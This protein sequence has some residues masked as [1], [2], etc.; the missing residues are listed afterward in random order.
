MAIVPNIGNPT[1]VDFPLCTPNRIIAV[2]PV[3]VVTPLYSGEIV[4]DNTT[5]KLAYY[6]TSLSSSSWVQF[7]YDGD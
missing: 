2:N 1:P 4:L 6:A 7:V 5:T 3:G